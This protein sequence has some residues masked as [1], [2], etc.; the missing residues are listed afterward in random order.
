MNNPRP[1]PWECRKIV[2]HVCPVCGAI[3]FGVKNAITCSDACR[4]KRARAKKKEAAK[5]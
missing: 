2:K 5:Q 3:F 4:S 1:Y